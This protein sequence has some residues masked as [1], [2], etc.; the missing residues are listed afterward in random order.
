MKSLFKMIRLS[1]TSLYQ[2]IFLM[3]L[4]ILS[5]L[6]SV[7][8]IEIIRAYGENIENGHTN[9]ILLKIMPQISLDSAIS[10]TTFFFL[11][12]VLFM[13]ARNI[14]GY[15]ATVLTDSI[16]CKVQQNLYVKL[17]KNTYKYHTRVS[18]SKKIHLLIS[19]TQRLELVFSQPFYTA[20]SDFFDLAWIS[21]FIYTINP[22]AIL[23][24]VTI[25][26]IIIFLSRIAGIKQREIFALVQDREA[27]KSERADVAFQG[28][29]SVK[30]IQA[31]ELEANIFY[32][33]NNNIL[34]YKKNAAKKLSLFFPTEGLFKYG[35]ISIALIYYL[36]LDTVVSGV[37]AVALVAF[38]LRFFA[39]IS[40]F[41]KYYQMFQ[42]GMASVNRILLAMNSHKEDIDNKQLT[43]KTGNIS[44]EIKNLTI[45]IQ[46]NKVRYPN[47][48]I[49]TGEH[50]QIKGESGKGKSL[51]VKALLG[52]IEFNGSVIIDGVKYYS[53]DMVAMR[54]NFTYVSQD[55][56]IVPVSLYDNLVY[57]NS[58]CY[59]TE[60]NTTIRELGLSHL[61]KRNQLNNGSLSGGEKKRIAMARALLSKRNIILLDEVNSNL[62][63][64]SRKIL[65]DL[66]SKKFVS[67]MLIM[68]SHSK[69]YNENIRVLEI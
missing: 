48:I 33:N 20:L 25:I 51:L 15:W 1:E 39:P 62:D 31:E 27:I 12:Y 19:D 36:S 18:S 56:Y 35:A 42:S 57:G 67:K 3:V 38:S 21:F 54:H 65:E 28:I 22:L 26:P 2:L 60:I 6:L 45:D 37:S 14:Y 29:D 7:L 63:E 5:S 49:K 64:N 59:D 11:T 50:I 47:F 30:A 13:I 69:L 58:N 61:E 8:P 4:G 43:S 53:S 34:N 32:E 44:L 10:V 66:I 68:I 17:L 52:L 46:K 16:I 9:S 41:N 24:Y 23:I 40:N 55:P